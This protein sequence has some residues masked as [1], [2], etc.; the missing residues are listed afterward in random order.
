MERYIINPLTN[1][2]I[3]VGGPV[4]NKL[5]E[6]GMDLNKVPSFIKPS[7][8]FAKHGDLLTGNFNKMLATRFINLGKASG[9][10]GATRGWG[11][12]APKKG[13]PRAKLFNAC[14]AKGH[15]CFLRPDAKNP[16]N[17]GFP[18]CQACNDTGVCSCQIDCHG[19]KAAQ[20]R[21][22]QW[23]YNNIANAAEKLY[24]NQC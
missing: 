5:L 15:Q 18:I 7:R 4:Y 12:A 16:G 8:S 10:G 19:V 13:A 14:D 21:A 9:H 6:A 3:L 11:A 23:K 2:Q 22:K 17:S 1:K 24:R 20:I